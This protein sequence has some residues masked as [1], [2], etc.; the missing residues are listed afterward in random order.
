VLLLTL[1]HGLL[2]GLPGARS[3]PPAEPGKKAAVDRHGDPLPDGAFARL[4]SL[5]FRQYDV[6]CVA[7]SPDGKVLASSGRVD[8]IIFWDPATGK[9]V[10]SFAGH[11]RGVNGIAFSRDGKLLASAGHDG[12][13]R[14]CET[15]TGRERDWTKHRE[16]PLKSVAFS[17]DGTMLASGGE[18]NDARVWDVDTGKELQCFKGENHRGIEVVCF[19]PDGKYLAVARTNRVELYEVPTWRH[20]GYLEDYE[21]HTT[22]LA[23]SADSRT[24][25]TGAEDRTIRFW[26]VRSKKELRCLG[27]STRSSGDHASEVRC[28]AVSPDGKRL[29]VGRM[30]GG[31]SVWDAASGK[32]LR[33]WEA[34]QPPPGKFAYAPIQALAFAPDG[35][36]LAT[37]SG[38]GL[39]LWD[40]ETGK[41]LDPFS[42][43]AGRPNHLVF[44]PDGKYLAVRDNHEILR[45]IET[46]TQK[47]RASIRLGFA[48]LAGLAFTPDGQGLAFIDEEVRGPSTTCRIRLLDVATGR[49]KATVAELPGLISPFRSSASL[50]A[51]VG[52][53]DY[54]FIVWDPATLKERKRNHSQ[55]MFEFASL[56]DGRLVACTEHSEE[57]SLYDP[58]TNKQVRHFG[59]RGGWGPHWVFSPDGRTVASP[60]RDGP[61]THTGE[62]GPDVILWETATGKERCRLHGHDRGISDI[63]FSGDGRLIAT[64]AVE[65]TILLWD[66]ATGKEV[67]RLA[68]HRGIIESLAFSPDGKVLASGCSDT[69]ILFWHPWSV[70]PARKPP[71]EELHRV[72]L[73]RLYTALGS[74]DPIAAYQAIG[75][76]VD[77]PDDTVPFI[78]GSLGKEMGPETEERIRSLRVVEVL[79]RIGTPAAREVLRDL[80]ARSKAEAAEDAKASLERLARR[81]AEE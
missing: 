19:S 78:R 49:V 57:L 46:S 80:Q 56:S 26:D 8:K 40:A 60:G 63:V 33:H 37:A 13:V 29:A 76:L 23:F 5:R 75:T 1:W 54:E 72:H 59:R 42:E 31:L 25:F 14:V 6:S 73:R 77:H 64:V 50:N 61:F 36:M 41:R 9:E 21:E 74:A 20:A 47:E 34:E 79:E 71:D 35:K 22:G 48:A 28:L 43:R 15:A 16:A 81:P 58:F 7:F 55:W 3:E 68:G 53:C 32:E 44:S 30:D 39:R 45:L 17:P 24:V 65:E 62:V 70:L 12:V 11:P 27:K 4:G 66:A 52:I 18:S 2:G 67:G 51:L 38:N 69:T 10:R